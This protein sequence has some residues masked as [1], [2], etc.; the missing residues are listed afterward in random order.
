MERR[1]K[2]QMSPHFWKTP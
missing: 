2:I 1:Q